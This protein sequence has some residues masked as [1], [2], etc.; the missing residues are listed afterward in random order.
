MADLDSLR[1]AIRARA[2]EIVEEAADL[3]V[4]ETAAAAPVADE[5]GGR[6]RDSHRRGDINVSGDIVSTELIA[7]TEYAGYVAGGTGPHPIRPV[8]AKVLR[9]KVGGTVVFAR[10]VEHPGTRPNTEWWGEQVIGERWRTAL[11]TVTS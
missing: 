10:H 9:F 8:F 11:G 5:N 6:L 7:D 4:T 2:I 3:V 1:D